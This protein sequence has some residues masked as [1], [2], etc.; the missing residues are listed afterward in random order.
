MDEGNPIRDA[1]VDSEG[2]LRLEGT[3][4]IITMER[5]YLRSKEWWYD[6]ST[7]LWMPPGS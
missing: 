3:G 1:S 4:R 2:N 7:T 6:P 5:A